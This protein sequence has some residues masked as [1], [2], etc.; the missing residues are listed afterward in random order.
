M[1]HLP[2]AIALLFVCL[3]AGSPA[4]AEDWGEWRGAGRDGV[5]A[6]SPKLIDALP[7]T[8]LKPAWVSEKIPSGFNGGWGS[9]VVTGGR[10]YLYAHSKELKPGKKLPKRKYP[11]LAPDKRGHLTPAEYQQY[12][13]NRRD[14]DEAL[15]K[16]HAFY[17]TLWCI[18][19]KT[20]KT[21]Y[22]AKTETV[23]TRFVQSGT[24]LIREGRAYVLSPG[25]VAK[26][27]DIKDGKQIWATRIPGD[28]RDEF[29]MS[30]F[31]IADGVVAVLAGHLVAFDAI[32]GKLIWQGHA[33]T[34][35][36]SHSSPTVWSKE[37]KSIFIVNVNGRETIGVEPKSGKELWRIKSWAGQSTPVIA[38]DAMVTFG[39]SRRG[40]VRCFDLAMGKEPTHRWTVGDIADKGSSPVVVDGHVYVQGD[41]NLGCIRMKDGKVAWQ[42]KL[43]M[44][45]PEYTSLLAADGK[46]L[47]HV[48]GFLWFAADPADYKLLSDGQFARDNV[49][50]T[51]AG[52]HKRLGLDKLDSAAAAKQFKEKVGGR[53]PMVACTAAIANGHIII[54]MPDGLACYDLRDHGKLSKAD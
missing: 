9:P 22:K 29:M 1:K 4:F 8:G 47:Y 3:V 7:S 11:W 25:R 36:G 33:K 44:S 27:F 2:L 32:T 52:H 5:A 6:N 30:S 20:G 23:Y 34:T 48:G 40:G 35:R 50:A 37:G 28:F 14:E 45:R 31:A 19:A 26:C 21:I 17:E 49:L 13:V 10:V 54:R 42:T 18:D 24:L 53:K 38:G 39:N 46:V 16:L 15:A 43:S 41:V 12:E 51:K